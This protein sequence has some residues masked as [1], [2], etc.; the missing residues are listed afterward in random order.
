MTDHMVTGMIATKRATTFQRTAT[1]SQTRPR[2]AWK[3]LSPTP[4]STGAGS[5]G[6]NDAYQRVHCVDLNHLKEFL[7]AAQPE[8]AASLSLDADTPTRRQFLDRI[9]SQVTSRGIIDIL[10]N[11]V[12]H[13]QHNVTLFYGTPTPGNTLAEERYLQNRFSVTRQLRYS[14]DIKQRSIDITLFINGL[15]IATIELKN[16]F[17]GRPSRTPS[18]ST[19]PPGCP[20]RTCSGRGAAQSTSPQTTRRSTSAPPWPARSRSSCPSTRA[21]TAAPATPSTQTA[22]RPPTCG[23]RS[24]LQ[25]DSPTSSKTMRRRWTTDKYGPGT[26][27]WT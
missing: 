2:R 15:P 22:S 25:V 26:T 16:R 9:K 14:N 23:R 27:S 10:R 5:L 6:A 12:R 24:S 18:S 20:R 17:T 3:P 19:R 7:E 13:N 11:G 21:G 1:W 4:S 8:T